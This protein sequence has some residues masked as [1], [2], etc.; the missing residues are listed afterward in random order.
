MN[1]SDLFIPWVWRAEIRVQ[2]LWLRG[3]LGG[4]FQQT[5]VSTP[6]VSRPLVPG[7]NSAA[8]SSP[9]V[10]SFSNGLRVWAGRTLLR[11]SWDLATACSWARDPAFVV[12]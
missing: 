3:S 4:G 5:P 12:P 9:R 11:G 6:D 8:C 10:V 2:Y 7:G 1:K